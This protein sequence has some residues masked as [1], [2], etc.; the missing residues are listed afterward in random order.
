MGK[1]DTVTKAY[2][3]KNNIFADAFNYLIYEGKTVVEPERLR[4]VDT[5]EIALPFGP[6]ENGQSNDLVQKYRD[7]LKSAVVMQEDEAAYILLG[8]ENQ[9]DI[10]YAMPV[11]NMIYDALQYGQQ[12]ADTAANHRK[13]GKSFRKRT[14]GEYLSGF[15]KEDVLK[16]VVTLV[17]HFGADE[18]DAPLSL[19]E[20]MGTQNEKLMHYV[21]DYQIHLIDP[22]KL[23][24]EDLKK[25]TSSL[26]EVIE[27]IKYSKDKE[28][29][30]RILKDNS[31]MLI[32]REAALVIKTITNTAIEISEKEEK[33][34]LLFQNT[35]LKSNFNFAKEKYL[36]LQNLFI[37]AS[38]MFIGGIYYR[39]S[40]STSKEIQ[41]IAFF[42]KISLLVLSLIL[43][44]TGK[45]FI[46]IGDLA[47]G[48]RTPVMVLVLIE[49]ADAFIDRRNNLTQLNKKKRFTVRDG[50]MRYSKR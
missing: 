11:R 36:M 47:F 26:R 48:G 50:M 32:D 12:V 43:T 45:K 44:F 40:T 28:K 17:I 1:V 42:M 34:A 29:L 18:W 4:E 24:E 21:Q 13:N 22:A 49:I 25:F 39:Y 2:M 33:Q 16:P 23:T 6:Q 46:F 38:V 35:A 30:S 8:I 19:H 37:L 15:Y 41:N 31:R 14:S 3:R 5:T 10:H 20:M 27:Y 9:T 7:I